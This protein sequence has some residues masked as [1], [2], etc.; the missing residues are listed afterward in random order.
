MSREALPCSFGLVAVPSSDY[1]AGGF[2]GQ[3]NGPGVEEC[4]CQGRHLRRYV[5]ASRDVAL[6][7][8][9]QRLYR[10]QD[11]HGT[12]SGLFDAVG[13]GVEEIISWNM[14]HRRG[15]RTKR[16][17][18]MIANEMGV[19]DSHWVLVLAGFVS[20]DWAAQATPDQRI[21]LREWSDQLILQYEWSLVRLCA[22][23]IF[24]NDPLNVLW[25]VRHGNV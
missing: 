5:C 21:R 1:Y 23:S 17:H 15:M 20:G 4:S 10:R 13:G 18:M 7:G 8:D 24:V 3:I 16:V 12:G 9:G 19:W 22:D 25:L 11:D 14:L 6:Q 2:A